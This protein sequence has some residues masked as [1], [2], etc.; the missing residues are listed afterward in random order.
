[1]NS[2]TIYRQGAK[3]ARKSKPRLFL[4]LNPLN[5]ILM[6][7]FLRALRAI[8][9]PHKNRFDFDFTFSLQP[10]AFYLQPS[11]LPRYSQL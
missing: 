3:D 2:N 4:A 11:T 10:S 7:G 9:V 8:A 6:Y 1:M 5:I